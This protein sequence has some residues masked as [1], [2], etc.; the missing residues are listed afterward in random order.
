VWSRG[1]CHP[2]ERHVEPSP[3][4]GPRPAG[5]RSVETNPR[6]LLRRRGRSHPQSE[7]R[8][9]K[10]RGQLWL[11]RK[12]SLFLIFLAFL[13]WPFLNLIWPSKNLDWHIFCFF[14]R[15]SKLFDFLSEQA[16]FV[17]L[18]RKV[19]WLTF[20][21]FWEKKISLMSSNFVTKYSYIGDHAWTKGNLKRKRPDIFKLVDNFVFGS[22]TTFFKDIY[23]LFKSS[24]KFFFISCSLRRLCKQK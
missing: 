1:Q 19:S 20:C 21:F 5:R 15:K 9:Q 12:V 23:D 10:R 2:V 14:R 16:F 22:L 3:S 6:P 18:G 17:S 24:F 7:D 13:F 8:R 11:G 4:V